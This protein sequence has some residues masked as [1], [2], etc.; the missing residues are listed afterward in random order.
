[1]RRLARRLERH[2]LVVVGWRPPKRPPP[3]KD[4]AFWDELVALAGEA[5][6]ALSACHR[7][8]RRDSS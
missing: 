5:R 6:L 4:R 7:R 3:R 2:A 1:V 8:L